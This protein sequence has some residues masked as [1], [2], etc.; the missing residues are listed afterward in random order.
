MGVK[1]AFKEVTDN[2]NTEYKTVKG[3]YPSIISQG[4]F[5]ISC[6]IE[7][8]P[9]N[10]VGKNAELQI[11]TM[12]IKYFTVRKLKESHTVYHLADFVPPTLSTK[13]KP[14]QMTYEIRTAPLYIKSMYS[15]TP[16]KARHEFKDTI[17]IKT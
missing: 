6:M 3:Y 12:L 10:S 5:S 7:E 13:S 14:T 15:L 11:S 8:Q 2:L 1:D 16:P 17:F 9:C 4:S